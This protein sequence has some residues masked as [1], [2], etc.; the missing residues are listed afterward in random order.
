VVD[1][2]SEAHSFLAMKVQNA[3]FDSS[4]MKWEGRVMN[5]LS[6]EPKLPK[7]K[8]YGRENNR[9]FLVM[10][11]FTGEDMAALRD[12]VRQTSS[13]RFI[14]LEIVS[15]LTRQMVDC[16]QSMHSKGYVHR[17][18]K[19]SNFVRRSTK[20]TEFC[21]IDFGLTKQV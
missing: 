4:V 9:D 5:D 17:D 13:S 2:T 15:Y 20:S 1:K 8:E 21:I 10:E 6:S 14:P 16:L 11:L 3:D 18:V 7:F 19:P 12:R